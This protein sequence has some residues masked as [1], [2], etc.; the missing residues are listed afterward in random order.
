MSKSKNDL[1]PRNAE[2]AQDM[3][4]AT[5]A[6][7]VEGRLPGERLLTGWQYHL[8]YALAIIFVG[9]HIYILNFRPMDPWVFRSV[10]IALGS[11]FGFALFAGWKRAEQARR[12]PIID[13][14]LIAASLYCT[15]YIATNLN[16]LLFRVGVIPETQD[17]VVAVL[18]IMLILELTRRTLGWALPV[19]ALIFIAYGFLGPYLPGVLE[20]RGYSPERLFTYVYSLNGVFGV[21][22][23]V[24]A[25]YLVIFVVFAAF[26]QVSGVGEYFIRAAFAAAGHLRGGPAKV[27]VFA[28]A[29]MGTMNGT[30]AGNAVATGSLTI[31]LM[32]RV[33]YKPRFAAAVEATASTGGQIL[34]PIMGAGAFIMAEITGIP[35]S[36]LILA[37]IIPALL[38]FVSVYFMVDLEAVKENLQGLPRS[39]IPSLKSVLRDSYLFIPVVVLVVSIL[40]GYS[41]IRAGTL[42]LASTLVASWFTKDYKMGPKAVADAMFIGTRNVIG[43]VAVCASAGIVVGMISLTG[44]GG[45]FSA[46]LFSVAQNSQF[47]ALLFAM[48]IAI[49]LG[50]GMPTT[51]AYAV[52]ASVVAPGLVRMDI[53]PLVAHMFVFYYAVV[54]AI[55]PPVALAAYATSSIANTDPISTSFESF[56]LGLAAYLVPFAFFYSPG[57]LLIGT[58][59]VI[60]LNTATAL[61]G[62]YLLASAVQGWFVRRMRFAPRAV[63]LFAALTLIAGGVL[64]DAIGVGIVVALYFYQQRY[65]L[66]EPERDKGGARAEPASTTMGASQRGDD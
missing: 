14:F 25:T 4:S 47:L 53:V 54:S 44:I 59:V 62:V 37:A 60:V 65:G 31:P 39:E 2:P 21:T 48:L 64:T 16:Q 23:Q 5:D 33:G 55:T 58:P 28:S 56:R 40:M 7:P 52:A 34:P 18:G 51:A 50:M 41:I 61:V 46:L 11:A 38:Y 43:L 12:V 30:S 3:H 36:Q 29:L 35:Y 13:W 1:P 49:I 9:F 10:H 22:T 57:L 15:Y 45:R 32:R 27:A 8:F 19:L 66:T 26:L 42:A 6:G 63:M 24:S 20:H 17:F